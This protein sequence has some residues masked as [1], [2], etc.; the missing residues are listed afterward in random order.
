MDGLSFNWTPQ[1][2][3]SERPKAMRNDARAREDSRRPGSPLPP[4]SP[5]LPRADDL[6]AALADGDVR[7][8]SLVAPDG[9][10]RVAGRFRTCPPTEFHEPSTA[11]GLLGNDSPSLQLSA[12]KFVLLVSLDKNE[13]LR[14]SPQNVCKKVRKTFNKPGSRN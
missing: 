13:G 1:V 14:A 5:P 3:L 7:V 4:L 11:P 10:A 9:L 8:G 2:R 6:D 12:Q